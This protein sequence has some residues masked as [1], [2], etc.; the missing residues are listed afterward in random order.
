MIKQHLDHQAHGRYGIGEA[1]RNV[2]TALDLP[3]QAYEQVS[4]AQIALVAGR[5]EAKGQHGPP[6]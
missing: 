5:K 3:I 6:R 2:G 4:A 1:A